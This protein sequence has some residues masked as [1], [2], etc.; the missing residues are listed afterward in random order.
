MQVKFRIWGH[1]Y[2]RFIT[3]SF[4]SLCKML[5]NGLAH[6]HYDSSEFKRDTIEEFFSPINRVLQERV[7]DVSD[8][9]CVHSHTVLRGGLINTWGRYMGV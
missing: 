3:L 5:V 7:V 2:L 1:I 9:Q 4:S 8:V 6:P